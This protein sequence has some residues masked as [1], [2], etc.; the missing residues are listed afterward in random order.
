MWVTL[1]STITVLVACAAC[2]K[3]RRLLHKSAPRRV[4]T[5]RRV[6][7]SGAMTDSPTNP[8]FAALGTTIFTHMSHEL[9]HDAANAT[10]PPGME[11]AY[12]GLRLAL[13]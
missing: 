8:I 5:P 13:T 3:N 7:I 2:P 1:C 6:C 10:L 4:V 11:L 9:D 12:D